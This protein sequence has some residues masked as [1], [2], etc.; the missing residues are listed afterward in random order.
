MW[1]FK[2][3]ETFKIVSRLFYLLLKR[4]ADIFAF[5]VEMNHSL[6]VSFKC[7]AKR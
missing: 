2:Y 5:V 6:Y 7:T 3:R 4:N 1:Y